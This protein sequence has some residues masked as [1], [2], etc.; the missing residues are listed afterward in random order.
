MWVGLY[1]LLHLTSPCPSFRNLSQ[2]RALLD[3]ALTASPLHHLT[4]SPPHRLIALPPYRLI[5]SPLHRLTAS[6]PACHRR[7]IVASTTHSV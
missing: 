3:D 6:P 2:Q 4:A 7:L 1:G 5:A